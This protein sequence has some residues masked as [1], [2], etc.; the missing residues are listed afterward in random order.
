ML[1]KLLKYVFKGIIY[2]VLF[3]LLG[4]VFSFFIGWKI[5]KGAYIFVLAAGV[6]IMI[7]SIFLLIGTPGMR[8]KMFS[9]DGNYAFKGDEGIG[10]AIIGI[11]LMV[12]GFIIEAIN[13]KFP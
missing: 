2:S 9:E 3:A 8:K 10:P 6:I 13:H 4:S 12:M 5:L 1:G 11:V 7:I